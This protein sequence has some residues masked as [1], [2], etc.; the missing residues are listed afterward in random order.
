M[1][2]EINDKVILVDAT[3]LGELLDVLPSD[4]PALIREHTVTSVCERGIDTHEGEFRLNFFY[5]N[6]RARVSVDGSGR[7]LRRSI[8]NF[9][10]RPSKSSAPLSD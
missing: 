3:L 6:R 2:V 10:D 8:V 1:Q 5:R 4:V 9:G 7:V